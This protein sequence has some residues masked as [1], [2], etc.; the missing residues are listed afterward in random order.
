MDQLSAPE[1]RAG[2]LQVASVPWVPMVIAAFA[3]TVLVLLNALWVL[4]VVVLGSTVGDL[5][6]QLEITASSI[7]GH[8]AR[9]V[10]ALVLLL[11]TVRFGHR[12]MVLPCWIAAVTSACLAVVTVL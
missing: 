10:L 3:L 6:T 7:L 12:G 9:P 2:D 5:D 11:L 4:A 8:L 1:A